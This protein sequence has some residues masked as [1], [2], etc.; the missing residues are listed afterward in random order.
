MIVVVLIGVRIALPY[1][2][3]DV[4]N[5]KLDEIPEYTGSVQDVD[6]HLYRGAYA[7]DSLM[8]DKI[9]DNN[10]VPF[11]SIERIDLSVEWSALF[12]GAIVAEIILNK[13]VISFIA[14]NMDDGEFGDEVD[15]PAQIKEM[16]PIQIDRFEIRNGLIR[17]RDFSTTP[18][19]NVPIYDLQLMVLNISN[20]HNLDNRLP[21]RIEMTATTVGEGALSLEADANLIQQIPDVDATFELEQVDVTAL[22][23]FLEA[24]ASVDAE[25]GEFNLYSEMII[26][27][28]EIEGYVKPI[29]TGLKIVDLDEGNVVEVAWEAIV[30][31]VT[32]V[33]ENQPEDQFAT[34]VPLEGNLNDVE[35]GTYPAIWNIFR[36]AFVNA[37]SKE[38]GG[39]I[40]FEQQ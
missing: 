19:V 22:N 34:E 37:F 39:E 3:K 8:I 14:P 15:W 1:W 25:G 31:F 27:D 35:A 4:I 28:G 26:K 9:E 10:E 17:Y 30:G 13:P 23:D 36:N 29:I 40:E 24:Y 21:S 2:V 18:E 5:Q 20:A 12:K 7:I 32:E 16:M 11:V 33:F 38:A 6:L